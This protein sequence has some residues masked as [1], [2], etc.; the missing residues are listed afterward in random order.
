[1]RF[2]ESS[3]KGDQ[4]S[5][6]T[7]LVVENNHPL[8]RLYKKLLFKQNFRVI[9][10]LNY[11]EALIVLSSEQVD[12]TLI[13]YDLDDR[14]GHKLI[15]HLSTRVKKQHIPIMMMGSTEDPSIFKTCIELGI[16][17]FIL[18]PINP[19]LLSLKIE[20]LVYHVRMSYVYADQNL[21]LEALIANSELEKQIVSHIVH[22]TLLSKKTKKI[23][24]FNFFLQPTEYFSGDIILARYA[25][26]GSIFILHADATGHGLTATVTLMP[27]VS[28]FKAMVEKGH[29]LESIVREINSSL[30][31]QLPKD[32]FV[33]ASLVEVDL[34]H[35]MLR[36]W[37]GG[38]PA[39]CVLDQ[40]Q[41]IVHQFKSMHMALG[42]HQSDT[43]ESRAE[44]L[45]LPHT[46]QLVS[47]SDALIEQRDQLGHALG[48]ERL[49]LAFKEHNCNNW[50][51]LL[52]ALAEHTG[53][54][55][56][57]DVSMYQ[58]SFEQALDTH[59]TLY[60]QHRVKNTLDDI[61]PFTW[62]MEL[63]GMQIA[64]HELP[65]QCNQFLASMGFHHSDCQ[66]IFT[67]ISELINNA[68]DHG[69]LKLTSIL[70]AGEDGFLN[71]Y[72]E[73]DRRLAQLSHADRISIYIQWF[74]DDLGSCLEIE[75]KDSGAGY[76]PDN[77]ENHVGLDENEFGRGLTLVRQLASVLLIKEQGTRVRALL[78]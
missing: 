28:V 11:H 14:Q 78:R 57:D 36:V 67:I 33:A 53:S 23:H 41:Q 32:L 65:S 47:Y 16:D 13:D 68:I 74:E 51:Q 62:S 39:L 50:R 69:L 46:A 26:S 29:R 49:I 10:A 48:I 45:A 8:K 58:L 37:N 40:H 77:T 7:I 70:K 42:I 9:T 56:F 20:S 27:V 59:Q 1:M 35:D 31:E 24:G 22:N 55:Q 72:Q 5:D 52:H 60:P 2:D 3:L 30:V 66:R 12:I 25:P 73:R 15:K 18:K 54:D 44:I 75:V 38:M 76:L 43:F 63:V 17:D 64:R 71:Y 4:H 19:M 6:I 34:N 21:K 61:A